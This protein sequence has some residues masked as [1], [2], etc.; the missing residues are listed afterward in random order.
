M[1][2][3]YLLAFLGLA[4]ILGTA[5]GLYLFYGP[6]KDSSGE[7]APNGDSTALNARSN[8]ENPREQSSGTTVAHSDVTAP[9]H[10]GSAAPP[11]TDERRTPTP[12][13]APPDNPPNGIELFLPV[14]RRAD[15]EFRKLDVDRNG[16]LNY[17]E[18]DDVLK[19]ERDRWDTNR[20]GFIDQEEFRAYYRAHVLKNFKVSW[21][22]TN[23]PRAQPA[24]PSAAVSHTT[25]ALGAINQ[26]AD[27]PD[28]YRPLDTDHDGQIGLYEWKAAGRPIAKFL[29]LDLNGDGFL[30]PDELHFPEIA[31]AEEPIDN[32][33]AAKAAP[34]PGNLAAY[35]NQIGQRLMFRVT[36]AIQGGVWGSGPYTCDSSLATAAVHAGVLKVGQTATIKV[37]I[38]ASPQSFTGTTAHGVTTQGFG[39]FPAAYTISK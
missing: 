38:V 37:R 12:K 31:D 2:S 34:D 36:G 27:L 32:I 30:T 11:K 15:A 35:Q 39:P 20:D 33:S 9:A 19:V 17:D 4:L 13:T 23:E 14:G 21:K 26:S 10:S 25:T 18:M 22:I 24:A 3:K 7:D 8:D 6:S 28:E 5:V 16:L 1:R 29:E